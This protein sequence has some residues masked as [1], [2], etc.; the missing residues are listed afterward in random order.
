MLKC[1]HGREGK[2]GWGKMGDKSFSAWVNNMRVMT[3]PGR[4]WE[5]EPK[6]GRG[7]IESFHKN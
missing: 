3:S 7:G 5:E 4:I 2:Y 6:W 1:D